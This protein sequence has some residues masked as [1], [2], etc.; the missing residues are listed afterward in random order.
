MPQGNDIVAVSAVRTPIGSFG[1]ALRDMAVYDLG[2]LAIR[3]AVE[4]HW[5]RNKVNVFGGGHSNR[6]SHRLLGCA[7]AADASTPYF[8]ATTKNWVWRQFAAAVV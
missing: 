4:H 2:A 1:G 8:A 3:S 7:F 6:S 5:D